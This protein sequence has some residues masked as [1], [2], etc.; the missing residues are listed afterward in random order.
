[1]PGIALT[2]TNG[3]RHFVVIKG[4]SADS[5]L[6]GDPSRGLMRVERAEFE[7]IWDGLFFVITDAREVAQRSFNRSAQWAAVGRAP[8]GGILS[9]PVDLEA[10]R[11]S[12]PSLLFG[13]L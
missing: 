2:V 4:V 13:E 9:R 10:V 8:I 7:K 1:M 5:V 3:Y 6:V 12:T 11:L